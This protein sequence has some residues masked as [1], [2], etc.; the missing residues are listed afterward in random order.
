M[1][2]FLSLSL[3]S[4][5]IS[6][7]F[8]LFSFSR[9]LDDTSREIKKEIMWCIHSLQIAVIYLLTILLLH[10]LW[11]WCWFLI[12][13]LFFF[14][15][16][17]FSLILQSFDRK[18]VVNEKKKKCNRWT[19]LSI[20]LVDRKYMFILFLITRVWLWGRVKK[21]KKIDEKKEKKEKKKNNYKNL[22]Q[23]HRFISMIHLNLINVL[24]DRSISDVITLDGQ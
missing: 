24:S 6:F 20:V 12:M 22:E 14:L 3:F 17:L 2:L 19:D 16:L 21:K 15:F 4:K 9:R 23:F 18:D 7:F 10:L 13:L 1:H 11:C 5:F 8:V